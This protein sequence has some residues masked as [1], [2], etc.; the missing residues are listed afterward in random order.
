MKVGYA[1][2][3]LGIM[4]Y[5][6]KAV[7]SNIKVNDVTYSTVEHDGNG[8]AIAGLSGDT[9]TVNEAMRTMNAFTYEADIAM[10][11]GQPAVLTFG[12]KTSQRRIGSLH[13]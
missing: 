2:E 7:I 13:L 11:A 5:S 3:R 9:H 4:T 12:I 8:F 10:N 6:S 1:G